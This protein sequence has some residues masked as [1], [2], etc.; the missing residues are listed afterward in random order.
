MA[1]ELSP[2]HA[3]FPTGVFLQGDRFRSHKHRGLIRKGRPI[4][5]P[6][7]FQITQGT[8]ETPL[9]A[10]D[11]DRQHI[12]LQHKAAHEGG[13]RRVEQF[14]R[15]GALVKISIPQHR[16][17]AAN[18]HGLLG[19]M[20]HQHAAGPAGTENGG[21][22]TAQAQTHLHIEI[23]EGLVQ[24]HHGRRWRQSSG[25]SEALPLPAGELMG[26]ARPE[27]LQAQQL[28]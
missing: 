14:A 24:K 6:G 23:G 8:T 2:H 12:A 18:G 25:Q 22:F 27:L 1:E 4:K 28:Q 10:V 16:H 13:C 20:G 17:T 21:Q 9:G 26:I 15:A 11:P 19:V 5:V 3:G 7:L